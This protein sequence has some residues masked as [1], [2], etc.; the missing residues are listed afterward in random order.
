MPVPKRKISFHRPQFRGSAAFGRPV[1]AQAGCPDCGSSCPQQDRSALSR[2]AGPADDE[3]LSYASPVPEHAR[4]KYPDWKICRFPQI[5]RALFAVL[6]DSFA[7]TPE[8]PALWK[9][10]AASARAV[11]SNPQ[12]F[13]LPAGP[14]PRRKVPRRAV[15]RISPPSACR[16]THNRFQS[17][18]GTRRS[19]E[20]IRFP[21]ATP[22]ATGVH[23]RACVPHPTKRYRPAPVRPVLPPGDCRQAVPIPW[24]TEHSGAKETYGT[25]CL[26]QRFRHHREQIRIESLRKRFCRCA[27]SVTPDRVLRHPDGHKSPAQELAPYAGAPP[28]DP[29]EPE[30][31]ESGFPSDQN[32]RSRP[33][34]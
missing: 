13:R 23:N 19:P 33:S 29:S 3:T 26:P 25:W 4:Q 24:R 28:A 8:S 34:D 30:S 27:I 9:S 7:G 20:N 22:P 17:R 12:T 16:L 21:S 31:W 15:R 11:C 1:S 5:N 14:A 6:P 2:T 10:R 18:C 32:D